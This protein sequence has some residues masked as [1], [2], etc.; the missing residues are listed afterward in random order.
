[1][2][3]FVRSYISYGFLLGTTALQSSQSQ[4]HVVGL[5][6]NKLWNFSVFENYTEMLGLLSWFLDIFLVR[7]SR[8][9]ITNGLWWKGGAREQNK[10]NKEK[11]FISQQ[12]REVYEGKVDGTNSVINMYCIIINIPIGK[13]TFEMLRI[14]RE[15]Y[16]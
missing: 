9:K 10:G 12:S 8:A 3:S 14:L 4:S 1:M 6:G 15:K 11:W 2:L 5:F 7:K 13:K 16:E